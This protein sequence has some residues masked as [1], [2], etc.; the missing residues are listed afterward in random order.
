MKFSTPVAAFAALFAFVSATPRVLSDADQG[1]LPLLSSRTASA[2]DIPGE[3]K[4]VEDGTPEKMCP[5]TITHTSWTRV[6]GVAKVPHNTII[7]D[8]NR[9]DSLDISAGGKTLS[10]YNSVNYD[11]E[12][13][14]IGNTAQLPKG[15]LEMLTSSGPNIAALAANQNYGEDFLIGYEEKNRVCGGQTVLPDRTTVFISRPFNGALF[16][17]NFDTRLNIGS[18]WMIVI[19]RYL[20]GACL[21]EQVVPGHGM[22]S[23]PMPSGEVLE[24]NPE[25]TTDPDVAP[26]T[27]PGSEMTEA[28]AEPEPSVEEEGESA[29]F[30]A[31]AT[32]ELEDGSVVAMSELS[33]GD[34]VH[35]GKGVFSQVFAFSHANAAVTTK[36]VTID[37]EAGRALTVTSG[38]YVYANER[39]VAAGMVKVG[40][41]MVL[42]E[43]DDTV[44]TAI[45]QGV[46][47]GLYNPQTLQ[48]DIAV[49]GL[50][51]STYTTA[52]EPTVAEA[53]LAPVR[54]LF[55]ATGV[56]ALFGSLDSGA[57]SMASLMPKGATIA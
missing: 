53:I 46:D 31:R 13:N 9:C 26:V 32:V 10:F 15:L 51:A 8:G 35:V 29:C 17:N 2:S 27:V 19:P 39:T 16:V 11:D 45:S 6:D 28:S 55:R 4:L 48:G 25:A 41:R 1:V 37:T 42:A 21:Y 7:V 22:D 57:P 23:E 54:A 40:D 47:S 30:P 18:R 5:M 34:Q 38:H 52:V 44:V 24:G 50:L 49:D 56:D 20:A 14:P 43:G 3:W 36:F 33:V 12:L